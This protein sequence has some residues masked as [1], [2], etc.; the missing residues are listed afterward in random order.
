MSDDWTP[1]T[2]DRVILAAEAEHG[3][4]PARIG[5]IIDTNIIDTPGGHP[6]VAVQFPY[7]DATVCLPSIALEFVERNESPPEAVIDAAKQAFAIFARTGPPPHTFYGRPGK[8]CEV[9]ACQL[10]AEDTT[11]EPRPPAHFYEHVHPLIDRCG[12]PG[13][14]HPQTDPVH[15]YTPPYVLRWIADL[16]AGAEVFLTSATGGRWVRARILEKRTAGGVVAAVLL[17][18]DGDQ[19]PFQSHELTVMPVPAIPTDGITP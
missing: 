15:Q 18:E 16:E 7:C 14:G 3:A 2:G 19:R 17:D 5:V 4:D 1:T 12:L 6:L 11:H 8:P 9:P 13:C 10:P